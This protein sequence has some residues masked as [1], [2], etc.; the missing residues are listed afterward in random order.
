MKAL[1]YNGPCDV[2][3]MNVH[4]SHEQAL[5]E[6]PEAYKHFLARDN[7]WTK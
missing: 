2:R 1:V 5:D 6:A 7:G 4:V 3:V